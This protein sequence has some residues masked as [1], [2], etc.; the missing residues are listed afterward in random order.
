MYNSQLSQGFQ[1]VARGI[2]NLIQKKPFSVSFEIT[3]SCNANCHHCDKGGKIANEKLANASEYTSI[4]KE[5]NPIVAQLSGGEPLLRNDILEIAEKMRALGSLPIIVLV[6]N[7]SLLTLE[8][9]KLLKEAGVDQFCISIDFPDQKHDQNRNIPGLFQH[10]KELIPSL[11]AQRNNDITIMTVIR[12]ESL[13]YLTQM[14]TLAKKWDVKFNLTCYTPLR[15]GKFVHFITGNDLLR[16]KKVIEKLNEFRKKTR[17]FIPTKRVLSRYYQY[18][19][20]RGMP[21]CQAGIRHLVVNPDGKLVPCAMFYKSG[22]RTQEELINKFSLNNKC[23]QC[24]IS[25]RAN[26]EK[27]IWEMLFDNLP[28]YLR[29][30][31]SH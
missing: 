3:H 5:L 6:T 25:M 8:K 2:K 20:N 30:I 14:A 29:S 26:S 22:Y 13:Q 4:C 18:F 21:G 23:D 17:V 28:L 9:Y 24:Y 31:L 27:P 11:A 16:L 15:T 1:A 19:Q 12:K 10:L 7:A